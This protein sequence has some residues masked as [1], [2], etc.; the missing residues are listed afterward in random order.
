MTAKDI[1]EKY[2]GQVLKCKVIKSALID[3][4]PAGQEYEAKIL[5]WKSASA[6]D[7]HEYVAVEVL[8]PGKTHFKIGDLIA[9]YHW[10]HKPIDKGKYGKRIYP[11]EVILPAETTPTPTESKPKVIPD[12]PHKCRDCG[13]PALEFTTRIDC[14]NDKCKNHF[15]TSSGMDLFLPKNIQDALK[16]PKVKLRPEVDQDGY[17]IC[18]TCK[19]RAFSGK[20]QNAAKRLFSTSCSGGHKWS[21]Q[22]EPGDRLVGKSKKALTYNGKSFIAKP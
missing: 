10:T 5:G 13:S 18:P 19:A 2:A 3:G 22:V 17:L 20:W 12:W 21:V 7:P 1:A 15:K 16:Q 4:I 14:S 9:G 6:A 8:P 11:E